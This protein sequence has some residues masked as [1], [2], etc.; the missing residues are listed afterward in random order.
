ME[1]YTSLL[2]L[3]YLKVLKQYEILQLD[4]KNELLNGT[5]SE[6]I[7]FEVPN[8]VSLDKKS[9]YFFL[10]QKSLYGRKQANSV[11]NENLN[12]CLIELGF[13]K[14]VTDPSMYLRVRNN[15]EVYLLVYVDDVLLAGSNLE[16]LRTVTD[17]IYRRFKARVDYIV[18]KFL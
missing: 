8:G 11:W 6:E 14:S 4:V 17:E 2:Y 9:G 5:L 12:S 18:D 15:E 7:S 10:L 16:S 3:L 1:K 13:K